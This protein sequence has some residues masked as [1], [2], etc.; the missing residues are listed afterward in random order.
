VSSP[1]RVQCVRPACLV[2]ASHRRSCALGD[3]AWRAA[4]GATRGRWCPS[5]HPAAVRAAGAFRHR[6][7]LSSEAPWRIA[8]A[9]RGSV[10]R[11][12]ARRPSCGIVTV[13]SARASPGR[14]GQEWRDASPR[15]RPFPGR[16]A[17][18]QF[19]WLP[20]LTTCTRR[21]RG[22]GV[23]SAVGISRPSLPIPIASRRPRSTWKFLAR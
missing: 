23:W 21:L 13:P 17:D 16:Q 7:L 18:W 6:Q 14:G 4:P 5:L 9:P 22:S 19:Y 15:D 11:H 12:L 20:T 1:Q 2:T 8:R 3:P 10:G